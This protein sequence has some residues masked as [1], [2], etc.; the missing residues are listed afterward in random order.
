MVLVQCQRQYEDGA[1]GEG[2]HGEGGTGARD[3]DTWTLGASSSLEHAQLDAIICFG[4]IE[5]WSTHRVRQT[6][7]DQ[8][9]RQEELEHSLSKE[10]DE[11]ETITGQN[12]DVSRR[13]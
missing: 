5:Q 1:L 10:T 9:G 6:K 11:D 3:I 2:E 4:W 13:R 8:P 12:I 7:C